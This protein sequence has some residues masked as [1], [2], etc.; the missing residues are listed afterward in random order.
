ME[1]GIG[2][3]NAVTGAT[4][5]Q[6][7]EFAREGEKQGFSSLGTIDRLVYDNYDPFVALGAAAAVTERIRL[8]TSVLIVPYRLNAALTAKQ[9]ASVHALSGGRLVVGAAIGARE[10]D[11][12]ASGITTE[13]RGRRFDEML[14][15]MKRVWEGEE[16]GHAG[17]IGPL[18]HG[19]PQ[20]IVGGQVDAAFKRA[21]RF[22]E[23]WI[24]GGGAPDQFAGMAADVKKAWSDAGRE[25]EPKLMSLAYFSLGPEA[26][27][28]AKKGVG[29]YYEWLGEIGDQ[30]VASVAT[31]PE[32]VRQYASAFE[33]A[34]CDELVF[35][36]AS[37]D[38]EQASLLAEALGK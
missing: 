5:E 7:V 6:L 4:G 23:G 3:P 34:G 26:E 11:Y 8:L 30:I 37:G 20:L 9:A 14:E 1:V 15:E 25:G 12:E 13:G 27:E 18:S 21:A 36:P 24:M 32:A 33:Q 17:A 10:D 31:D 38:P 19:A 35:F 2:L 29:S 28:N 16:R 22:A